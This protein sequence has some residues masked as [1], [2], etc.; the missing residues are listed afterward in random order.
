[1]KFQLTFKMMLVCLLSST[2]LF[3]TSCKKDETPDRDKFIGTYNV[4]ENCT[5]GTYSYSITI[6]ESSSDEDAVV[7][8]NFG[9][10][11]INARADVNGDNLNINDT[12]DGVTVSGSA[13]ING[14][15]LTIIYT[16]SVAGF[17]DEC[18]K[19]CIKQ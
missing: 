14:S 2:V 12:Q 5:S 1:M 9:D 4:N 8:S 13:S 6:S 17:T 10:Y 11:G 16:A 18:T 15:T 3:T 7:I 19:T